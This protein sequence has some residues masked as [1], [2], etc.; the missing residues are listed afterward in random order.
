MEIF[1][2]F[3]FE[4]AHRLE[5]LPEGHKCRRLHGHSYRLRVYVRGEIDAKTGWVMD[6]AD[7]KKVVG[8]VVERLDHAYL[9]EIEG[10]GIST[11]E[12]I[13][14]WLWAQLKPHLGGLS[15]IELWETATSGAVYSGPEAK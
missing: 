10:M 15:K 4:A 12:G 8:P 6:F 1:K 11:S 14:V 9:N 2:E 5:H 7:I 3:K 13:C